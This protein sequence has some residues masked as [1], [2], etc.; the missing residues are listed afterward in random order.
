MKALKIGGFFLAGAIIQTAFYFLG[1][2][3]FLG[4]WVGFITAVLFSVFSGMVLGFAAR[5]LAVKKMNMPPFPLVITY[6]AG[7]IAV[8]AA[9][10]ISIEI[11]HPY[12]PTGGTGLGNLTNLDRG[13]ALFI[14]WLMAVPTAA[15]NAVTQ[16]IIGIR[17]KIKMKK[18]KN[19]GTL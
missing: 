19:N 10:R 12:I 17:D 18:E 4:G 1:Y 9:I 14:L 5:D 15:I 6:V 7:T 16:L 3:G 2:L 8:I 11:N 13:I